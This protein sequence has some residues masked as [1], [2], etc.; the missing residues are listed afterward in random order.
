M[1]NEYNEQCRQ[2]IYDRAVEDIQENIEY[3]AVLTH[4][5]MLISKI[6]CKSP[7]SLIEQLR[8]LERAEDMF[9]DQEAI[10][11]V[12]GGYYEEM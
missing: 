4:D 2:A 3:T 5:S 8:K 6:T 1:S 11:R 12:E 9:I 7:E 10:N